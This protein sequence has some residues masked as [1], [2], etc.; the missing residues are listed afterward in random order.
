M[1]LYDLALFLIRVLR[2]FMVRD[3]VTGG[4]LAKRPG[5]MVVASNHVGWMEIL[6][7]A[8][9]FYPRR[10]RF[11]GKRELFKHPAAAWAMRRMGVFPIN[12]EHPAASE[13]KEAIRLLREGHIIGVLAPGTRGGQETKQGAARLALR[14]GVPLV[15]ARYEGVSAPHPIQLF[16][17]P[18]ISLALD[19]ALEPEG[20]GTRANRRES[21]ELT[22]RVDASIHQS[23]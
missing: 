11:M 23:S 20:N 2:P 16:T 1:Y 4:E 9:V 21:R 18:H 6:F 15:T 13:W 10:V 8:A 19:I 7:I 3:T 14:A 5:A 12:R 17:R 22:K